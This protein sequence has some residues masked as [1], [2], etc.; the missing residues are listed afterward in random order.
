MLV[1]TMVFLRRD[2]ITSIIFIIWDA[3]VLWGTLYTSCL[4]KLQMGSPGRLQSGLQDKTFVGQSSRRS[5]KNQ[6]WVI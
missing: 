3:A 4:Q 6:S 1:F 2:N 5:K